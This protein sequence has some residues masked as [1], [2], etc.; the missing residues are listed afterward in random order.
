MIVNTDTKAIY[1]GDGKTTAFPVPFKFS[2][3]EDIKLSLYDVSLGRESPVESDFFV[4]TETSILYYPGYPPGQEPGEAMRPPVAPIGTKLVIYRQTPINQMVDMGE[5]YPLPIIEATVDKLTFIAQEMKEEV[6][7]TIKVDKGA[8]ENPQE[9]IQRIFAGA[10][11]AEKSAAEAS[12]EAENAANSAQE[13]KSYSEEIGGHI[14]HIEE[15]EKSLDAAS[16]YL[17]ARATVF[18]LSKVY[19]PADVVMMPDGS[20]YRCIEIS[21]G[22]Y[23]QLSY[24]WVAVTVATAETFERDYNND[25]M[26]VADPKPS[27]MW[28]IDEN[29]DIYIKEVI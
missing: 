23:P 27:A 26:P 6:D 28:G 18:E 29:K 11:N 24:K 5:K 10:E 1:L 21:T 7:R 16:K 15:I 25:I 8:G 22:E 14:E 12:T 19:Q 17:G 3:T 4:D 2:D 13:A 20:V 9:L